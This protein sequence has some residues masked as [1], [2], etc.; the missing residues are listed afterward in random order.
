MYGKSKLWQAF[1]G[2]SIAALTVPAF[3]QGQSGSSGMGGG[4]ATVQ[5]GGGSTGATGTAGIGGGAGASANDQDRAGSAM[6]KDLN[7]NIRQALGADSSVA[8]TAPKIQL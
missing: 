7:Q 6:D 4:S 2:V 8:T 5:P 1:L 3:A